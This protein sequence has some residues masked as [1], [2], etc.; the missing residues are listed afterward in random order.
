MKLEA[1]NK[2]F[3]DK[4][5][6]YIARG[7]IINV[8]S[9]RGSQGEEGKVDLVKGDELIR[10]WINR[11]SS[12]NWNDKDAWH[13]SKIVLRV[14]RWI[15]PASRCI[16]SWTT[17]WME[18]LEVLSETV[19]YEIERGWYTTSDWTAVSIQNKR[20]ARYKKNDRE[21]SQDI[22]NENTKEIAAKYLK[23][24]VGY[25]R[26]SINDITVSKYRNTRAYIIN[27]KGHTYKLH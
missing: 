15:Y 10:I 12:H 25:K 8:H 3:T 13:G 14:G 6:E 23:L 26:V 21:Y 1:I 2:V 16:D 27:Y 11:E 18:D 20:Y 17:V 7:Y 5:A 22:T 9:M 24:R 19:Y 4:V